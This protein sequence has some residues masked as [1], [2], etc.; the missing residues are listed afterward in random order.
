MARL[1]ITSCI[2]LTLYAYAHRPPPGTAGIPHQEGWGFNPDIYLG[3]LSMSAIFGLSG[4]LLLIL[5]KH[6]DPAPDS[7]QR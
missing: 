5:S 4:L 3:L 6:E 2:G 1:L 7:Y